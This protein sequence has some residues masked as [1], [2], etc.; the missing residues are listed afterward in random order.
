MRAA[1]PTDLTAILALV[2]A[3]DVAELGHADH[4][5]ADLRAEWGWPRFELEHDAWAAEGAAGELVGY[6]S[7]WERTPG[8]EY[9]G[10]L[11]IH[12]G[13]EEVACDP[14]IGLMEARVRDRVRNGAATTTRGASVRATDGLAI[15]CASGNVARGERL[16]RRG[17]APVRGFFRM[18]IDLTTAPPPAVLP[19]GFVIRAVRRGP[20]DALLH[21]VVQDSFAEHFRFTPEPFEPWVQR[22]LADELFAPGLSFLVF[23]DDT[24]VATSINYHAPERGWV[25]MLGVRR[26]WRGKG[27]GMA[28][29][30]ESFAAF[31]RAGL[32]AAVLGVDS[33]NADGAVHLYERAGMRVT[34]RL[35]VRLKGL[36][37]L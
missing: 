17:Y 7:V 30:R 2:N 12:P 10:R 16:A 25:G 32:L 3:C 4:T 27:L 11:Y 21:A 20:D 29:L 37:Q 35:E 15:P 1:R 19:P 33:E 36:D 28:L 8:R 6:A 26:P 13:F 24:P 9:D 31:R 22:A 34:Q 23:H 5:E 18:E 14:L